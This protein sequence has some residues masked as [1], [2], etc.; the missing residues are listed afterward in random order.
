MWKDVIYGE[1]KGSYIFQFQIGYIEYPILKNIGYIENGL[2]SFFLNFKKNTER[3]QRSVAEKNV[4]VLSLIMFY[5]NKMTVAYKLIGSAIYSF[6]DNFIS[7]DYRG[8]LQHKLFD[9]YN[10][11]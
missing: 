6:V 8:I 7:L 10:M 11:L 3:Y 4:L 9:Y 1:N 2:S 5:H